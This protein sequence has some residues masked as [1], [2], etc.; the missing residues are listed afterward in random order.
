MRTSTRSGLAAAAACALLTGSF[1]GTASAD[2]PTQHFTATLR[3]LNGSGTTGTAVLSYDDGR[4]TVTLTVSGVRAGKPHAQHI[5]GRKDKSFDATCPTEA[6]ADQIAGVPEQAANPDEFIDVSEG[7]DEYGPV[8]LPFTPFPTPD[9]STYTYTATF[10][11]NDLQN[12]RPIKKTLD[13]RA[14]VVHG[15]TLGGEYVGSLPVACG[16]IE[17]TG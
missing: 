8:L 13:E 7:L 17:R 3:P 2:D 4:L 9:D 5:H 15:M 12:L 11:G 1:A 14:V 16:T 10:K 6:S